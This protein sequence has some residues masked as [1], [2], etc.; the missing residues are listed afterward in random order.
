MSFRGLA[1]PLAEET[2]A[3]AVD[4]PDIVPAAYVDA[5]IGDCRGVVG[6]LLLEDALAW[7]EGPF[8]RE[9]GAG[10]AVS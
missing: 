3:A 4:P 8:S 2:F 6:V 1:E 10:L 9:F 7:L 5:E